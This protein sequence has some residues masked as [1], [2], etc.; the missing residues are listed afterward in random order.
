MP[1]APSVNGRGKAL[2]T[3]GGVVFAEAS[4]S[5][6]NR[7]AG[8][9][10]LL[11]ACCDA[12]G[13]AFPLSSIIRARVASQCLNLHTQSDW[14]T[15]PSLP[16]N[17]TTV[18]DVRHRV[19][20][21]KN[22]LSAHSLA[23]RKKEERLCQQCEEAAVETEQHFLLH[24]PKLKS[25]RESYFSKFGQKHPTFYKLPCRP[26]TNING[27]EKRELR[28]RRTVYFSLPQIEK[29]TF[30]TRPHCFILI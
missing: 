28:P 4:V 13:P 16:K 22:R 27:R 18:T 24:C 20:L 6:S 12:R 3:D 19:L 29:M 14:M 23:N 26:T 11:P 7:F 8:F 9:F 21:T 15:D 5:Q 17:L 30:Y 25:V 10:P 2:L 1:T